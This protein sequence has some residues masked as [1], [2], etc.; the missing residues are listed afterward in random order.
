MNKAK[1]SLSVAVAHF[2]DR[3]V[4]AIEDEPEYHTAEEAIKN[5]CFPLT[6][7]E[8]TDSENAKTLTKAI[9]GISM[10]VL[11][12]IEHEKVTVKDKNRAVDYLIAA[13][14][15]AEVLAEH[16]RKDNWK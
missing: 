10:K 8:E 3:A 2:F 6:L 9:R 7:I 13:N 14:G 11:H 1:Y 4:Y 15:L 5:T 12:I 16:F